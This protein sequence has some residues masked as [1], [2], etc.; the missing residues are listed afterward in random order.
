MAS[1][2]GVQQQQ[3]VEA[4]EEDLQCKECGLVMNSKQSLNVHY[5]YHKDNL[6][7]HWALEAASSHS[8]ETNNNTTKAN[9][10]RES[11]PN[12]AAATADSSDS[13]QKKSPEYSTTTPETI[14][15]HPPTPQS[16]QSA[17]SPYQSHDNS[18]FSP[19]FHCYQVKSERIS[20]TPQQPQ[21][22]NNYASYPEQYFPM[23]SNQGQQF[24]DS[25]VHKSS[26]YRYHPYTQPQNSPY[27]RQTQAQVSSSSPAFPPQPT[28]SPSPKQCDK[29]GQ[30]CESASQLIEHLNMVHPPT[31]ASHLS[32]YQPNQ[33][34]M[35]EHHNIKQ[36]DASQSEILDLDSHKVVHNVFPEDEK[37]HNGESNPHSVTV[38]LP[39]WSTLQQQNVQPA[40]KLF[41]EQSVF[42]SSEKMFQSNIP[43]NI[44]DSKMFQ[45]EQK[46]FTS[47]TKLFQ[48]EQKLFQPHQIHNQEFMSSGAVT[49]TS[50]E[51]NAMNQTPQVYRPFEHMT[52][53]PNVPV[54]TST[55][56]SSTPVQPPS[57]TNQKGA[58][59]KSNEARRPKTYNCTA[60]NKWFTSSGHL[61]RHYNTTLHKNA[62]KSSGQPDPA[63]LPISAHHHPARDNNSKQDDRPQSR[64]PGDEIRGD[65]SSMSSQYERLNSMPGL[66]Q[67]PPNGPYDRQPAPNIHH[68]QPLHS[69]MPHSPMPLSPMPQ[70][71]SPLG[72]HIGNQLISNGS[73]PNGDAGL[74]TTNLDSRGLLS[75]SSQA[76][77]SVN[78][79]LG[80]NMASQHMMS[81]EDNQYQMYPNELA[82]HV[83]QAMATSNLNT[84]GEYQYGIP[85]SQADENQPLPSFQQLQP[86]RYALV[87][88]YDL[89]NVGGGGSVTS[90]YTY[91]D[92]PN[93]N[94]DQRN[95]IYQQNQ[96]EAILLQNEPVAPHCEDEY[97]LGYTP[98]PNNNNT[99][100][101]LMAIENDPEAMNK[102]KR[103]TT[104]DEIQ[105]RLANQPDSP[106][107]AHTKRDYQENVNTMIVSSTDN[108]AR[109]HK[110]NPC[111]K[112]F[113]KACYLTQH[114][115]TFH[116][117]EKPYKC[118]RCGKRFGCEKTYE[119][120]LA[121]HA[122]N[123]PHKCDVSPCQKA[124]NHKT[125]LRRHMCLHTGKKPYKCSTCEKGFI[126]KDHMEKH[127]E[128]HNR[129][130]QSKIA[131]IR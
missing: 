16:Y 98:A 73:P 88:G 37:P 12:N 92:I 129:K 60:C 91:Y 127:K 84:T 22:Q 34:F 96:N 57:S 17:N 106:E 85:I 71:P 54:I 52:P 97:I 15:G 81:M 11:I 28:P 94:V 117:G 126:R 13:F 47:E 55:G 50:P 62:V 6:L 90:S 78:T 61:K 42:S 112:F 56:V 113:N 29:C 5:Q 83:I 26:A 2:N 123:K 119:V 3:F 9:I 63:S 48:P 4:A 46:L 51:G 79:P 38:M 25:F 109:I 21:Y 44:P 68:T 75:L 7:K 32:S 86:N 89:D 120:H 66:L 70:H 105:Y 76:T 33:H 14:F 65:D 77:N 103:I 107:K 124:F 82:P 130:T 18:T 41:Q 36:E 80:F 67:H 118:T 116:S 45:A 122:G 20:P 95:I 1:G 110:C 72:N 58:N 49:T 104:F 31:P 101:G 19:N 69:P 121:K 131:A 23:D 108:K 39:S 30:V 8:E 27:D 114:N 93:D 10:K 102:P 53:Q 40:Q 115:K 35:F 111:D 24:Q 99:G 43:E 100:E 64:S 128:T 74:S 59:W 125:D 87:G